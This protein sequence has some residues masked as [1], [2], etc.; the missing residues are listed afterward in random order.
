MERDCMNELEEELAGVKMSLYLEKN[1]LKP[2]VMLARWRKKPEDAKP[3]DD[4]RTP[5]KPHKARETEP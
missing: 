5:L 1:R 3:T 4:V 2:Q